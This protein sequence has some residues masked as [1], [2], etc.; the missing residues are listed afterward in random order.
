M[1][2]N[3]CK[4]K[5]SKRNHSK[6]QHIDM[7]RQHAVILKLPT[8]QNPLTWNSAD[9]CVGMSPPQSGASRNRQC[10]RALVKGWGAVC[11][12]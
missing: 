4:I 12:R 7:P 9:V 2:L 10:M 11:R 3:N 8:P 5:A 6:A 1:W